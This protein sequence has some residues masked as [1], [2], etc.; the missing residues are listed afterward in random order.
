MWLMLQHDSPDDFVCATGVSHTVMDLCNYT[1]SSFGIY[2][3]DHVT[4]DEKYMRPEELQVLKGD[5]SKARNILKW[6]NSYSFEEM[7]DEMIE[8]WD[9]YYSRI[10]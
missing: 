1:F 3:K 5:P 10:N 2:Y 6:E 8:Y 4:V 7:L 9:N